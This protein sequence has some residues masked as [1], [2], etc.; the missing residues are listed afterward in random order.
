MGPFHLRQLRGLKEITVRMS[1]TRSA[2][3]R[4]GGSGSD[5]QASWTTSSW[6]FCYNQTCLL[7]SATFPSHAPAE[8]RVPASPPP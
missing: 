4:L 7:L 1:A 5:S 8:D 2:P 3:W 6:R